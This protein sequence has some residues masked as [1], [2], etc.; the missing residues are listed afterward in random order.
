MSTRSAKIRMGFVGGGEG[1]FIA[2]AHRQA[3]GLDGHF[4]LVCGAFSR[5]A[6]NNQRTAERL[7]IASQRCYPT[8]Q[9]LLEAETRLPEA[10]RMELLVI[11]T[12]NHLHAPVA[13]RALAA[14]FHVFSE[15]PAAL[16]LAEL[17]AL[18]AILAASGRLYGLA[19]TYLGYPMVWQ[20][21]EMVRQ[22]VIG[23]LR[24]VIVEYPQG[25]L[26][27]DA[28]GQGSKQAD[29]R[30]QPEFS[31]AG[32][33][34]GDIG[35]HAFSLA[36]F[37]S[38]Q[39][40]ERICATL[41]THIAGR[42]LDDDASMLFSTGQGVTGVLIA[43]QVCAGEE[44]ALNIRLYGDKG[45][46]EWRQEEPSSLRH[47]SLLQPL[48][49][50]RAG[51]GQSWLCAAASQR[52]RLPPGHPEGYLE[53]LANLYGDFA[54]AIRGQVVGSD[55]P[56]VPGIEVGLR[57]MAFIETV[58]ASHRGAAKWTPLNCSPDA[59]QRRHD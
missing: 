42:K 52:M 37:V 2:Q 32:G 18:Q 53:A 44:N 11:V 33:C 41:G 22:G 57:G 21:R 7:G 56:G 50:L 16:R 34:I 39:R 40:I 25:W 14:G 29:W 19:H 38:G 49:M 58:L 9:E 8:W 15:K 23:A 46:L 10:Q 4:E 26:S 48:Q 35:T 12:P 55:V 36:E 6:D 3:A 45:G 20:A 31:G 5:D 27:E 13:S 17:K 59:E 54:N 28:A 51:T 43:S 1:A 47:R 30:D 24:K